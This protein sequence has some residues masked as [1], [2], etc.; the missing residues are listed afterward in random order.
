MTEFDRAARAEQ[1]RLDLDV[2]AE[3]VM[4]RP[5]AITW[6]E[7]PDLK[8]VPKPMRAKVTW[9]DKLNAL[10]IRTPLTEDEAEV[11]KASVT[12]ET[13]GAA[14]IHAAGISRTTAIEFFQKPAELSER[15][16]APLPLRVHGEMQ[17]FDHPEV[18]KYPGER[19]SYP[20]HWLDRTE[21]ASLSLWTTPP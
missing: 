16:R 8:N 1:G 9:D 3:R 21:S 7:K 13:A 19:K 14:I 5:V 12:T 18:L 15:F 6:P 4:I 11:L 17:S 2:H 20:H 10:T